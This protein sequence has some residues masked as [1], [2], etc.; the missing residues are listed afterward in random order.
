MFSHELQ[1]EK[2]YQI[3]YYQMFAIVLPRV[4]QYFHS[5]NFLELEPSI[6]GVVVQV[7]TTLRRLRWYLFPLEQNQL[8]NMN[9]NW[10]GAIANTR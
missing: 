4:V 1:N 7:A 6:F 5:Y 10:Y 8:S 3:Q 9:E 2:I